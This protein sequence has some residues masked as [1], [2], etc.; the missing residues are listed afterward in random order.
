LVDNRFYSGNTYSGALSG[1]FFPI[2]RDAATYRDDA[3]LGGYTDLGGIDA[4]LK[5]QFRLNASL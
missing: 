4:R 1:H 3:I 5:I 2:A